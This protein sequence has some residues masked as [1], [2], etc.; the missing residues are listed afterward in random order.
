M[1]IGESMGK[2]GIEFEAKDGESLNYITEAG[3]ITET[4]VDTA[5]LNGVQLLFESKIS[6][7]IIP[8]RYNPSIHDTDFIKMKIN[9]QDIETKLIIGCDGANSMVRNKMGIQSMVKQYEQ[10]GVVC[11]VEINPTNG[12]NTAFQRFLPNS[13]L[14]FLPCQENQMS[15]VWSCSNGMAEKLQV[16]IVHFIPNINIYL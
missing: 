13:I 3:L 9:D 2:G 5:E 15:I 7:L 6:D 11:T 16:I 8:D 1:V 14:A 12:N 4:L 10:R